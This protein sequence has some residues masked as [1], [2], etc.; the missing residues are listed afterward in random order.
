MDCGVKVAFGLSNGDLLSKDCKELPMFISRLSNFS[1]SLEVDAVSGQLWLLRTAFIGQ[2]C[3]PVSSFECGHQKVSPV[4]LTIRRDPRPSGIYINWPKIFLVFGF[5]TARN[6]SQS[7]W[8]F[9]TASADSAKLS[10]K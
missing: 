3:Q 1:L 9:I 7:E 6:I 5:G 2:C 4:L 8:S 10:D